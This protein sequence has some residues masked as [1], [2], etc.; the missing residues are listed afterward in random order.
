MSFLG[1]FY[2]GPGYVL[3]CCRGSGIIPSRQLARMFWGVRGFTGIGA[4]CFTA[5][6]LSPRQFPWDYL[7]MAAAV[8]AV[9]VL[10]WC[11]VITADKCDHKE[12]KH[13]VMLED[14]HCLCETE[15]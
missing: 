7:F 15:L 8:R 14:L 3:P 9:A 10:M 13:H 4:S 12:P 6:G 11:C 2:H 5:L 1:M